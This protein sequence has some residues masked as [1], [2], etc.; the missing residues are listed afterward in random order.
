[1]KN[2]DAAANRLT[3]EVQDG[4]DRT[5]DLRRQQAVSVF[6]EEMRSFSEGDRIQFTAPTNDLKVANRELG[7]IES[8]GGNGRLNL[9]MDVG[10][11]VDLDPNSHVYLDYGYAVTRS[12]T[13]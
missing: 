1:V 2:I 3:V 8:I 11:A 9:R 6:R 4:T 13:M 12:M 10:Q 7:T 5:Y